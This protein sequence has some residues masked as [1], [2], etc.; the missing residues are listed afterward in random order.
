[1]NYIN[2]NPMKNL[3]LLIAYKMFTK[4]LTILKF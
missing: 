3:S 1:M 2:V 4:N